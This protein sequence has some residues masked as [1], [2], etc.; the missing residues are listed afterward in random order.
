MPGIESKRVNAGV[1]PNRSVGQGCIF[2]HDGRSHH[3]STLR[4]SPNAAI[5][6]A[7][8]LNKRLAAGVI[9][10]ISAMAEI[11]TISTTLKNHVSHAVRG[12]RAVERQM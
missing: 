8:A 6:L 4:M 11:P 5:S 9:K 7:S 3:T 12:V 10:Y 2:Q 1:S